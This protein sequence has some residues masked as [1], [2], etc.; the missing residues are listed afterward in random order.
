[1][2]K[3]LFISLLCLPWLLCSC[4]NNA[5]SNV[6]SYPVH[7][8]LNITMQYPHFIVE[9][10]FQTMTVVK[11]RYDTDYIGFGGVLV[12]INMESKYC[13]A[14][15]ACP[16]CLQPQRPVEVDGLFAICPICHE[17]FD[18]STYAFPTKGIADQPLRYYQTSYSNGVLHIRN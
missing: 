15:M 12:W 13:A 7:L 6:P 16:N 18:L 2:K 10:G 11:K 9:N 4:Y 3:A 8:D 14:D 5:N 1:M 17:A